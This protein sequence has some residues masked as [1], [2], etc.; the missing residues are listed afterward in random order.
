M[1]T[2]IKDNLHDSETR[3]DMETS[4]LKQKEYSTPRITNIG[5]INKMTLSGTVV[6][7]ADS[8]SNHSP[9]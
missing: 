3:I 2:N 6:P 4:S 9:S 8:G 5:I 1:K 7:V